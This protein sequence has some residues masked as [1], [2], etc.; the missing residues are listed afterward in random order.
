MGRAEKRLCLNC[1]EGFIPEAR[2]ARHQ[3][4][5]GMEACKAASKRA[6]QA[7]WLAKPENQDYHRG[8]GAVA[9]VQAWRADHPGYSRR[10]EAT[11]LAPL[12]EI[13]VASTPVISP[14][15]QVEQETLPPPA[16]TSCNAP[17]SPLQ[18][19]LSAQPI[20]LVGLI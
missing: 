7:R 15:T 18:D 5:C 14:A 9:R 19:V 12:Q 4:Y 3:R 10:K 20:V 11:A 16:K 8:P 13:S 17:A 1:G 6:S 2:N